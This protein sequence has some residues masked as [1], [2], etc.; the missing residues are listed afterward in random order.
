MVAPHKPDSDRRLGRAL[1]RDGGEPPMNTSKEVRRL[2][3]KIARKK[4]GILAAYEL[5]AQMQPKLHA[6]EQELAALR[7]HPKEAKSDV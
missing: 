3:A 5:I 2:E 7:V 4:D 1:I 6:L